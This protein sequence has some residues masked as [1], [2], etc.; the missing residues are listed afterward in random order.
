MAEE[1]T[2][3]DKAFELLGKVPLP[4]DAEDQLENLIDT[5]NNDE[6][7][8]IETL[9]EALFSQREIDGTA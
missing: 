9:T 1:L 3:L 5:A 4:D 6:K 7:P 8:L 2:N